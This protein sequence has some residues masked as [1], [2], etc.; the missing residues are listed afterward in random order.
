MKG[1]K[2]RKASSIVEEIVTESNAVQKGLTEYWRPIYSAKT[3]GSSQ[4]QKLL[5][6]FS[7]QVGASFTFDSIGLPEIEDYE[8]NIAAQKHSSPGPDG[9]PFA[10]YKAIA[11]TTAAALKN[12]ADVFASQPPPNQKFTQN[13]W[14]GPPP[15][16]LP[17]FPPPG[18]DHPSNLMDVRHRAPPE[19]ARFSCQKS[20]LEYLS[21]FN[22]QDVIFALRRGTN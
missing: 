9:V 12:L 14:F 10:A 21:D 3:I 19:H 4:I 18:A 2:I 6:I 13:F 15:S 20:V 16:H 22:K 5:G 8:S 11:S 1:L 7:R 17:P